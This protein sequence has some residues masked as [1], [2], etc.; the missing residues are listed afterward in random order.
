MTHQGFDICYPSCSGVGARLHAFVVLLT[1]HLRCAGRAKL[2]VGRFIL[3]L[4]C[5]T[6]VLLGSLPFAAPGHLRGLTLQRLFKEVLEVGAPHLFMSSFNEAI[7]GRQVSRVVTSI[8]L[9][10]LVAEGVRK[11]SGTPPPI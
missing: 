1:C 8:Y 4:L 6:S 2:L 9:W 10:V 3:S 5:G 7:G 11:W